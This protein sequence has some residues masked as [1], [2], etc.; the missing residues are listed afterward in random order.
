MTDDPRLV[1]TIAD[2]LAQ[3]EPEWVENR[4]LGCGC[5]EVCDAAHW[6]LHVADEI[7]DVLGSLFA[8]VFVAGLTFTPRRAPR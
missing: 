7:G 3:H 1:G 5:G 4:Q 6:A 2:V 8:D